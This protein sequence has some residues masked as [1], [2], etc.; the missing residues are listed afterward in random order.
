M[1]AGANAAPVAS[2][3]SPAGDFPGRDDGRLLPAVLSA[4]GLWPRRRP[5]A[6]AHLPIPLMGHGSIDWRRLRIIVHLPFGGFRMATGSCQSDAKRVIAAIEAAFGNVKLGGGHTMH[7]AEAID[8]YAS[9]QE[10]A[11]ARKLDPYDRWQ[12]I[13]DETIEGIPQ[14]LA[15]M[16]PEGYRFHLPRFMVYS[17]THGEYASFAVDAPIY[18]LRFFGS[19]EGG[20]N[21]STVA[22]GLRPALCGRCLPSS[23][24]VAR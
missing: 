8:F 9:P 12:D 3:R 23:G 24:C 2:P 17:I 6:P 18:R 22:A 4:E 21:A 11:G 7:Q 10:V 5:Q 16:D 20:E 1:S 15:F 14:A 19:A 13:P